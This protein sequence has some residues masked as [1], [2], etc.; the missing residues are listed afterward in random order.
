MDGRGAGDSASA[1][2][3]YTLQQYADDIC[4]M[5]DALGIDRFRYVGLSMGGATGYEL[6]LRHAERL[7]S[8]VL[9]APAP[10]DGIQNGDAG[11][12]HAQDQRRRQAREEMLQERVLT[13][14]RP[15]ADY[16]QRAVERALNCSDGHF[17]DAWTSMVDLRAGARLGEI[18]TPVLMVAGAADGLLQ[19]N[20][21]DFARLGNATLHVFS[22]VGHGVPYEVPSALSRVIADFFEHG[23][24]TAQTLRQQMLAGSV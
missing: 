14:G 2:G 17:E 19:S 10:A 3:P 16:L 22:R 24:V 1:P 7:E 21:A 23:V 12:A 8:M 15:N 9:V 20:L 4:G 5:A 18:K 6:G 11:H 13:G